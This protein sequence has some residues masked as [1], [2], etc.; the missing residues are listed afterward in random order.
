MQRLP[1]S[2]RSSTLFPFAPLVRS[3]AHGPAGPEAVKGNAGADPLACAIGSV[4]PAAG[5]RGGDGT[6]PAF[7][8]DA[9]SLAV[10]ARGDG[11][12]GGRRGCRPLFRRLRRDQQIVVV[13]YEVAHRGHISE[14]TRVG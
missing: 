14:E 6:P 10:I 5:A 2:T 11:R 7:M 4:D 13:V 3:P 1:S 8:G 12:T 9:A